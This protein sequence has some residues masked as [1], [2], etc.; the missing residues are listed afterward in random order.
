MWSEPMIRCITSRRSL[1]IAGLTLV[2]T[3][4]P[5][6]RAGR[7]ARALLRAGR[8]AAR[9]ERQRAGHAVRLPGQLAP[10]LQRRHRRVL[11]AL[12][13]RAGAPPPPGGRAAGRLARAG[14][15]A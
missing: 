5:R 1:M 6:A 13:S 7:R 10:H 15:K 14:R 4:P 11:P 3:V 8:A 2:L 12:V 9:R